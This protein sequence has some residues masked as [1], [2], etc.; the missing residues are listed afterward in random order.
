M[1]NPPRGTA[2]REVTPDLVAAA[3]A[4]C[5]PNCG[6]D[7][8]MR[9][10]AA[11]YDGIGAAAMGICLAWAG[12]RSKSDAAEDRAVW[13]SV[14][15]PGKIKV[16]TLFFIAKQHGFQLPAAAERKGGVAP[17]VARRAATTAA[18]EQAEP[19][20][21]RALD[22]AKYRERADETARVAVHMFD[23]ASPTLR[24]GYAP[25]KGVGQHGTRT[26]ADRT[27]YVPMR[28]AAREIQNLQR[29]A[30]VKPSD[31]K[32][33]KR[34]L[35]GGRKT[36]LFHWCGDPAQA[37]GLLIAEGYATSA[38]IFEATGRPCAVAFDCGNLVHVAAGFCEQ[39]PG[40]PILICGDDDAETRARTGKNPGRAGAEAAARK[41]RRL[42]G[43]AAAVFPEGL[44]VGETDFNDL[45]V[46][47]GAEAVRTIINRACD[48]LLAEAARQATPPPLGAINGVE[49][50]G[51][52]GAPTIEAS[53]EG[54][55][56]EDG[57]PVWDG[58]EVDDESLWHA[59]NNEKR[60]WL[61]ARFDVVAQTRGEGGDAFG[62]LIRF[63]DMDGVI[64]SWAAPSV[65]L[66][67]EGNELIAQLRDRGLKMN[68]GPK[69]RNAIIRCINNWRTRARATSTERVGWHGAGVFVLPSGCIG[70]SSEH[71]YVFQSEAG[72]EDMLRR[73]GTLE[74][75]RAEVA[76]LCRGNRLGVMALCA[77]FAGPTL[78]LVGVES[79]IVNLVGPSSG[80]KTTLL[81]LA[82]SVYGP[83]SY[84]QGWRQTLNSQEATCVQY[85]DLV[86]PLDEAGQLERKEVGATA[87]AIGNGIEKGRAN[88]LGMNR[89]RR[90]W[91]VQV[92]S[93]SELGF[94]D[95]MAEAGERSRAGQEVRFLDLPSDAGAGMGVFEELHGHESAGAFAEA[96]TGAA[97]RGYGVAGR[98]WIEWLAG[99]YAA[100]CAELHLRIERYRAEMLPESAAAQVRR[101][102]TRFALFA[103]AGEMAS[104]I[105]ITGWPAGEALRGVRLC[106]EAWLAARG[107]LD[108]GEDAQMLRQVRRFLEQHAEGRFVW[109]HRAL[110]D[111]SPKTLN[112]AG[113]RRLLNSSGKPIKSDSEHA[114]EFG[115]RICDADV[116]TAQVDFII[117]REAFQRGVCAGFSPDA[118]ARLLKNRGHL[119]GEG[120]RL[121]DRQRLPGMGQQ[122][123][124]CYRILPSI[125]NDE[126]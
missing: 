52:I 65:L 51:G 70:R 123:I 111:R 104:E 10:F 29:I 8:R 43:I 9:L 89:R 61:C 83:P 3:F 59:A 117:L 109:W 41:V 21:K 125:F 28:N 18:A 103:A 82:G 79:G 37:P 31:G 75:W 19:E 108:N 26:A 47:G 86:L 74:Q 124:P 100:A 33:E 88:R 1:A 105:G 101:A 45:A 7:E 106:F 112:R 49:A 115:P 71:N 62:Y 23:G 97:A 77:A 34:F 64:K 113:F 119:V 118:V 50:G 91:R 4:A 24:A 20:R 78:H 90:T 116:E 92:I 122:K 63:H 99:N 68:V 38:S 36:G 13:R 46:H 120:D 27:L 16:N 76:A 17:A 95:L 98:A 15:K 57:P 66:A 60:H 126:L 32:P 72:L 84:V 55:E 54:S 121:T 114:T 40:V 14:C 56:D 42:G 94:G 73:R 39:Y 48:E 96:L 85:C 87:Y 2:R 11:A 67:G 93:S 58:F 102:S 44:P 110:D 25:R 53:G 30:P 35:P 69:V 5:D 12:G 6:H 81:R 22:E 107:H 80:G